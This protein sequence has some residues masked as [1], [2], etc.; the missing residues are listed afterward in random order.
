QEFKDIFGDE[1]RKGITKENDTGITIILMKGFGRLKLDED[2][3]KKLN[4]YT[5]RLVTI[6]GRTQIRAGVKRPEIIIPEIC[7]TS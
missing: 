7:D 3:R 1:I 4:K 5:G 2:D 6:D